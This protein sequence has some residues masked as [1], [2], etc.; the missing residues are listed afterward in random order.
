VALAL[1]GYLITKVVECVVKLQTKPVGLAEIIVHPKELL[2]P[3]MSICINSNY[4]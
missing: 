4:N 3:S 1:L 2:Y